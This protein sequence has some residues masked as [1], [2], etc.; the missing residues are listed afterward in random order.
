MLSSTMP[1]LSTKVSAWVPLENP[2]AKTKVSSWSSST[3]EPDF[4]MPGPTINTS[5]YSI[6]DFKSLLPAPP[7]NVGT[8]YQQNLQLRADP[9]DSK[10]SEL[11]KEFAGQKQ[12]EKTMSDN[13]LYEQLKILPELT[14]N[15]YVQTIGKTNL[16]Y[17]G[18]RQDLLPGYHVNQL[19]KNFLVKLD[20]DFKLVTDCAHLSSEQLK[21]IICTYYPTNE[22]EVFPVANNIDLL[23]S[24]ICNG[25]SFLKNNEID[26]AMFI[27]Y[28]NKFDEM[29]GYLN[30]FGSSHKFTFA[31]QN[32]GKSNPMSQIGSKFIDPANI[33]QQTKSLE[34]NNSVLPKSVLGPVMFDTTGRYINDN[35]GNIDGISGYSSELFGETDGGNYEY[36]PTGSY[37]NLENFDESLLDYHKD[38]TIYFNNQFNNV[39]I[40]ESK[41][42]FIGSN[43]KLKKLFP[44]IMLVSK[45]R[46]SKESFE[47]VNALSRDIFV[48]VED[49]K[50]KLNKILHDKVIDS[51]LSID[52]IKFLIK[53][54]FILDTNPEHCIK[55]TNI[56]EIISSELKVSESF[57]NYT[58]RQLPVILQDLGL[59]KKRLSD[60]IYWYGLVRKPLE[61]EKPLGNFKNVTVEDKPIPVEQFK[62]VFDKYLLDRDADLKS[63]I[64]T[65]P[66]AQLTQK[67]LAPEEI[68]YGGLEL[69]AMRSNEMSSI[70]EFV[71]QTVISEDSDTESDSEPVENKTTQSV[72][73]VPAEPVKPVGKTAK[74]SGK[75]QANKKHVQDVEEVVQTTQPKVKKTTK[76]KAAKIP[77]EPV[78]TELEKLIT[79]SETKPKKQPKSKANK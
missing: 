60:G 72:Q 9:T 67:F 57:V 53:K 35:T 12:V 30:I 55:F 7:M 64:S 78:S 40:V 33:F 2:V 51:K 32:I 59:N 29:I 37:M 52:E 20:D 47:E 6:E 25:N 16:S 24:Y 18:I 76:A 13:D 43:A 63:V 14:E 45:E 61:A 27:E 44:E 10:A 22:L 1:N 65:F 73:P 48:N 34:E 39:T 66:S 36:G 50:T 58:K 23:S 71:K 19:N 15:A 38:Y 70:V 28:F 26:P 42:D 46:L 62:S 21:K 74:P 77:E 79:K 11:S 3:I 8:T 54:Y 49:V 68:K 4:L 17:L 31:L 41:S 75:K 56:W 69:S 5:S